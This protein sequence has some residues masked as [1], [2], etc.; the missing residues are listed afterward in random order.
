MVALSKDLPGWRSKAAFVEYKTM[1]RVKTESGTV[2][3]RY[4]IRSK[5]HGRV[6]IYPANELG[7]VIG[8]KFEG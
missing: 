2:R 5:M 8:D 6:T 4:A 3:T 7:Q 1:R